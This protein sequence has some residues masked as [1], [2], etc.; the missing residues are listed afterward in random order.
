MLHIFFNVP[1]LC[2]NKQSDFSL[3]DTQ[4]RLTPSRGILYPEIVLSNSTCLSLQTW[5]ITPATENFYNNLSGFVDSF[6]R[7]FLISLAKTGPDPVFV[8]RNLLLTSPRNA[9]I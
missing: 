4:F 7:S 8:K 6:G 2:P 3:I 5:I 9:F 1:K